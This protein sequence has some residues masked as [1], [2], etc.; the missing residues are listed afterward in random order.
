MKYIKLLIVVVLLNAVTANSQIL[1]ITP[2]FPTANDY[3]TIIYDATQGN[4]ALTDV[5]PV[6]AHCGLITDQ[7]TTPTDWKFIK[8]M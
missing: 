1:E 6:Y 5:S 2:A 3:V 4:G 7:S 8:T